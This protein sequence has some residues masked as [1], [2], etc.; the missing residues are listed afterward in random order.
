MMDRVWAICMQITIAHLL[1]VVSDVVELL[2]RY[3]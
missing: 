1:C 2:T 3:N